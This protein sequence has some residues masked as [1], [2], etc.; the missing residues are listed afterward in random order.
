M[1]KEVTVTQECLCSCPD[2]IYA[3]THATPDEKFPT[4]QPPS[5]HC[6]S[7]EPT[8]GGLNFFRIGSAL[9]AMSDRTLASIPRIIRD[10]TVAESCHA[11]SPPPASDDFLVRGRSQANDKPEWPP[12]PHRIGRSPAYSTDRGI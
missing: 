2:R 6:R 1:K 12:S 7:S 8:L 9:R 3:W 11:P 10:P 4:L 5:S